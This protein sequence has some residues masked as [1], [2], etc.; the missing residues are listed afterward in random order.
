MFEKNIKDNRGVTAIEYGLIV[1][2]IALAILTTA[3]LTGVNAKQTFCTVSIAI[4]SSSNSC[5]SSSSGVA[6]SNGGTLAELESSLSEKL[7][8]GLID[9]SLGG[10]AKDEGG[11]WWSSD[12]LVNASATGELEG[13]LEN[14][15]KINATDPITNV[16]GIYDESTGKPITDYNDAI[17]G[18]ENR[19]DDK[20]SS[21]SSTYSDDGTWN[22]NSGAI[23]V[24]TK[25]GKAYIISRNGEYMNSI[26]YGFNSSGIYE[27][28]LK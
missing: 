2:G 13:N 26:G 1:S 4:G 16:F 3:M 23:E 20:D 24:T 21:I 6:L 11:R 5:S 7:D 17:I 25:S 27:T 18:I 28:P 12:A 10:S 15:E 8:L 9:T 14:L 22:H 19:L